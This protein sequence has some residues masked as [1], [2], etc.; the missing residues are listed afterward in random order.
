MGEERDHCEWTQEQFAEKLGCSIKF[1]QRIEAG[2]ENLTVKTLATLA[3][4]L[5]V[6]IASLF[7]KPR[8]KKPGPGRP[9]KKTGV[10]KTT[11]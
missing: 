8:T 4:H 11:K 7:R 1:A 6:G 5:D 9:K 10:A 2:R 3:A